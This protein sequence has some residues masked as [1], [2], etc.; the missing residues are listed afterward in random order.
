[1]RTDVIR[2]SEIYRNS[3]K[4]RQILG[5]EL[6]LF[7][8]IRRGSCARLEAKLVENLSKFPWCAG[9]RSLQRGASKFVN[10]K[11]CIRRHSSSNNI[12]GK[13]FEVFSEYNLV[14]IFQMH[15][16]ASSRMQFVRGK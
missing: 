11:L 2:Y 6:K 3:R 7:P 9:V 8:P 5:T 15:R 1:M 12:R 16:F 4:Y 14:V 10:A 13:G